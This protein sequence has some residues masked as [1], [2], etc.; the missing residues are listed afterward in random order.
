MTAVRAD[1]RHLPFQDG[2][3][4]R[5]MCNHALYHVPDPVAAVNELRRVSA[6]GGRVVLATNGRDH[7]RELH[8][9]ALAAGARASPAATSRFALEDLDLVRS[10]FPSAE[11]HEFPAHLRFPSASPAVDYAGTMWDGPLLEEIR[12]HI[13]AVVARDGLFSVRTRGGCFVANV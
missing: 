2:V 11:V 7:L 9:I 8:D 1:L 5:T 10:V 13:E 12:H 6:A 3:F 4:P